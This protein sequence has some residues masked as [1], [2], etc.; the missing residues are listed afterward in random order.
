MAPEAWRGHGLCPASDVFSFGI[1]LW[2]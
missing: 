2:E 1:M